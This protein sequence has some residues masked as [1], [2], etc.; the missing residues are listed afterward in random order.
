MHVCALLSDICQ[1]SGTIDKLNNMYTNWLVWLPCYGSRSL[2]EVQCFGHSTAEN[3]CW[4][5]IKTGEDTTT[6][7]S[8]SSGMKTSLKLIT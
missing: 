7:A 8:W 5:F 3:C 6:T 1:S 2:Y 4:L